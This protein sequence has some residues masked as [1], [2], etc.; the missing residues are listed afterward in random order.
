MLPCCSE[1]D[2]SDSVCLPQK[3]KFFILLGILQH[4]PKKNPKNG[5]TTSNCFRYLL[6][7]SDKVTAS[8]VMIVCGEKK[9]K[10]QRPYK[11]RPQMNS[12]KFSFDVDVIVFV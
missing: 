12:H 4:L 11:I 2:M 1:A 7:V 10:K 5:Q 8:I 3:S 9:L 6:R